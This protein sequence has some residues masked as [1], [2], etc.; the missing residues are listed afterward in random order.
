MLLTLFMISL[1]RG[2]GDGSF[3]GVYRCSAVDWFLFSILIIIGIVLTVSGFIIVRKEHNE[4]VNAGYPFI[5]EDLN[6]NLS[7]SI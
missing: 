2:K 6:C 3:F 4:K 7:T 5:K 1:L